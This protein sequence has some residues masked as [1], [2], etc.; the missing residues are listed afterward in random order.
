MLENQAALYCS[1]ECL[2][3]AQSGHFAVQ[4]RCL[5]SGVKRTFV[6]R[7]RNAEAASQRGRVVWL[8]H[9]LIAR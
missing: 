2:L 9:Q 5:L 6:P 4:F 1:A 8:G 7:P 3:L